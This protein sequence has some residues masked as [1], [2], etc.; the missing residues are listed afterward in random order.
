MIIFVLSVLLGLHGSTESDLGDV[1]DRVLGPGLTARQLLL[2]PHRPGR[3]RPLLPPGQPA[4]PRRLRLLLSH[5]H[6][7]HV[8]LRLGLPGEQAAA[9]ARRRRQP[10]RGGPGHLPP[11]GRPSIPACSRQRLPV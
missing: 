8:L 3:L 6:G 5:H 2:Q 7:A 9:Q 4:H 10:S 11:E 1:T